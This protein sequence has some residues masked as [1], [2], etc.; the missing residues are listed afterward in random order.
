[1]TQEKILAFLN[2]EKDKPID[3]G[4]MK[5]M[6][7]F[8]LAFSVFIIIVGLLF[9]VFATP[10]FSIIISLSFIVTIICFAV[11]LILAKNPAQLHL[12][13]AVVTTTSVAKLVLGS[14]V[15][16][17]WEKM[18]FSVLHIIVTMFF[19]SLAL[20]GVLK[21]QRVLK[22]L[23]T[24]SVKQVQKNLEKKNK[25]VGAIVMPISTTATLGFFLSRVLSRTFNIGMGFLL[26]V[27]ASI[28]LLMAI[29]AIYNY[30]IAKKYKVADIFSKKCEEE[31]NS[32][33][34][35]NHK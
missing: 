5:L 34:D 6:F 29:G 18:S 8:D 13:M 30:I 15:V 1:M 20:Y 19:V 3:R 33:I 32:L 22:E 16:S 31:D 35:E 27:L 9:D 10:V 28:W 17:S 21:K 7:W 12:Y 11:W 23:K 14:M 4:F 25:G 24:N 2:M 26:W